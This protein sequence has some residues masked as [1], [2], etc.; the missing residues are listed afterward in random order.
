M[1]LS[2]VQSKPRSWLQYWREDL[3]PAPGRLGNSLRIALASVLVLVAMMVLQ[4]PYIAYGLYAI[5]MVAG[6]NPAVSLRSG[7]ATTCSVACA[8]SMALIIVIV[9]DNDPMARVLS[10]TVITFVAGMITTATS[11]PALGPGWG[12]IFGVGIGLWENHAPADTLVKNSLWLLAAFSTGIA[13][14]IVVGYAFSLRSPADQLA[15]QLRTRYRALEMMFEAYGSHS[16]DQ[17][18]RTAAERVS[19]LAAAGQR[20]MLELY[21]QIFDRNLGS[22]S[23]PIGVQVHITFLAELLDT[24]AAFGLQ[25]GSSEFEFQSRCKIIGQHCGHLARELR[26]NPELELPLRD[27][28]GLTHLDR[29][30]TI[31]RS[32]RTIPSANDDTESNVLALPS[33][34]VPLL[35]PG[36]LRKT[37]NVAFALKI[38]LCATI[39]YILYHAVDWSGISTSV[40]TV[41]VAGLVNT[42]AMKQKLAFRILGAI[43]GG[44]VLGIGAEAFLFPLMDS[45]TSLVVVIGTVAFISAWVAGGTRFNY[46]GMQ[47]AFAF[48]ITSLGGFKAPTELAPARDRLAGV[49]LA[50]FVMWIVFDQMWPVRTITAMRRLVATVLRDASRVVALVDSSLPH[51]DYMREADALRDGLGTQLATLRILNEAT[52]YEFGVERDKHIAVGDTFMQMSMTA[53]AM[54]WNHMILLH[55]KDEGKT[56]GHATLVGLRQLIAQRLSFIADVLAK[57]GSI[58]TK[59]IAETSVLEPTIVQSDSEYAQHTITRYKEIQ[60]LVHHIEGRI[61]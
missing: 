14:S 46:V 1:P 6:A 59:D 50:V 51:E 16:A 24:S 55:R 41:M 7:I 15:E 9:T 37:D 54:V 25:A 44:L 30:E 12:L 5:F 42:G 58:D 43:L 23:L 2:A 53:V 20:G 8:L 48:Y 29:V 17:Q 32:L 18:L 49:F 39:C 33:K 13:G 11:M 38:S 21:S 22:G 19:R 31:L 27:S 52:G 26:P 45:I 35:I 47:M 34:R 61:H 57:K 28:V 56:M 36:A 3:H 10:L 60:A 4:V 40:T